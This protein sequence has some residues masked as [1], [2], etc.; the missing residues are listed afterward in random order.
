MRLDVHTH[1]FPPRVIRERER[2][3]PGEAAFELLYA[4]PRA[5]L[6]SAEELLAAL[7]ENEIDRAVVFGFPWHERDHAM[8]HN[9]YVLEAAARHGDRFIALACMDPLAA[10]AANEA[11]RCFASGARGLG[12]L[13][14]YE[15]CCAAH[16]RAGYAE[17]IACC[18]EHRGVLLVHTNEPVGHSYPGKA[19]LGL[20]FYYE[21]ARAAAGLPL[22]FAH[23]GGGLGF[24]E[25]LKKEAADVLR[26]VFYDTAASPYLYRPLI[27]RQMLTIVGR[28][29]I[30]FGSDFPLLSPRRYLQELEEAGVTAAEA[31]AIL[32]GNAARLFLDPHRASAGLQ[33][34]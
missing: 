30:L 7:D 13:A 2:F 18:R 31:E 4:G 24:F 32:G 17:L 27:Y 5:R 34:S 1:I 14:I 12:E 19:P 8:R 6:A 22:I 10:Y 29:K 26:Q 28:D 20:D 15:A 21:V 33:T 11:A 25:L 9:D 23:W 3:F 16:A